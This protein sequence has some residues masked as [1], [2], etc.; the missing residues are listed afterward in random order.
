MALCQCGT[1]YTMPIECSTADNIVVQDEHHEFFVCPHLQHLRGTKPGI[2]GIN[3][4]ASMW[5]VFNEYD[6]S[7]IDIAGFLQYTQLMY[8][9]PALAVLIGQRRRR[10]SLE[11]QIQSGRLLL[12][13]SQWVFQ[14]PVD[15]N[16]PSLYVS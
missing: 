14:T 5:R 4:E 7:V 16:T 6:V 12:P 15:V 3:R 11:G 1:L 2:F 13:L 9:V 10:F 8:A